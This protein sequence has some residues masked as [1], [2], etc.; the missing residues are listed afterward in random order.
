MPGTLGSSRSENEKALRLYLTYRIMDDLRYSWRVILPNLEQCGLLKIDYTDL[1]ELSEDQIWLETPM[2][3]EITPDERRD[4]L[5]LLVNYMRNK[6]AVSSDNYE[7]ANKEQNTNIIRQKLS[8]PWRFDREE[9]IFVPNWMRVEPVDQ[10]INT[11]SLHFMSAWGRYLKNF[12]NKG[13]TRI[14]EANASMNSRRI[15]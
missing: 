9:H 15:F 4:L 10:R 5:Y 6:F 8:D 7:E 11:E 1:D 3:A 13:D 2:M 12:F 14:S